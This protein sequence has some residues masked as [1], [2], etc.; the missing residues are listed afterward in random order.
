VTTLPSPGVFAGKLAALLSSRRCEFVAVKSRAADL[1]LV[2]GWLAD[3]MA[4]PIAERFSVR[5]VKAALDALAKGRLL[6]RLAVQVEGD[7]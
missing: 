2:A 5:D 4:V 3:T 1:K 6:G 7:F